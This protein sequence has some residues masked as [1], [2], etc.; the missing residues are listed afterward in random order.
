MVRYN[1]SRKERKT[2]RSWSSTVWECVMGKELLLRKELTCVKA[3]QHSTTPVQQGWLHTFLFRYCIFLIFAHEIWES[4][5]DEVL[6]IFFL[7]PRLLHSTKPGCCQM[8]FD[9]KLLMDFQQTC[10][11]LQKLDLGFIRWIVLFCI[12]FIILPF[13]FCP[14]RGP[15]TD[16]RASFLLSFV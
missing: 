12:I 6:K 10:T 1:E 2:G 7:Q 13:L 9:R 4:L 5:S 16:P 3:I 14:Q 11:Q 8:H 15:R